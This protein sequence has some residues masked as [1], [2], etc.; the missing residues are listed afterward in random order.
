MHLGASR[1]QHLD[2]PGLLLPR[3]ALPN[4]HH[5]FVQQRGVPHVFL[6]AGGAKEEHHVLDFTRGEMAVVSLGQ[7]SPHPLPRQILLSPLL[8]HPL[9]GRHGGLLADHLPQHLVTLALVLRLATNQIGQLQGQIV[10][11]HSAADVKHQQ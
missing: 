6:A 11:S 7:L 10:G 2:Q 8:D 1:S 4:A 3:Q 9:V 5:L